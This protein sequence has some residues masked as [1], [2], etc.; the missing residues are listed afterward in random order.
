MLLIIRSKK[1]NQQAEN[2]SMN[3]DVLSTDDLVNL[4]VTKVGLPLPTYDYNNYR[5][6]ISVIPQNLSFGNGVKG[7]ENAAM[8]DT[9]REGCMRIVNWYDQEIA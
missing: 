2:L 7:V 3:Y 1:L 8:H 9:F 5:K 6:Y 4:I